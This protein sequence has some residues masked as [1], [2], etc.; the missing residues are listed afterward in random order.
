[1]DQLASCQNSIRIMT[2]DDLQEVMVIEKTNHPYPWSEQIMAD[3]FKGNY[4]SYVYTLN[5]QLVGYII[6]TLTLDES[7]IL[8]VCVDNKYR[9]NGIASQLMNKALEYCRSND[10]KS[11]FLEVRAS[12]KIALH[13]YEKFGF[14]EVGLRTGYYPSQTGREDAVV[15]ALEILR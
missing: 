9:G 7:N 5:S 4:I 13:L 10:F 14:V 12:N 1:M 8:N 15:M 2:K 3:C 6:Q 11:I